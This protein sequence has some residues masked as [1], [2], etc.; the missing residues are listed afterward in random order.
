MLLACA[1]R[2]APR[3]ASTSV[4][5]A[6]STAMKYGRTCG[7][8][9]SYR[10]SSRSLSASPAACM[11]GSLQ[12]NSGQVRF[13]QQY[14][15]S[16]PHASLQYIG[17]TQQAQSPQHA[18]RVQA[19]RHACTQLHPTVWGSHSVQHSPLLAC[20]VASRLRLCTSRRSSF[21]RTC[22]P[23]AV[24]TSKPQLRPN[25][26][27]RQPMLRAGRQGGSERGSLR[28][29]QTL[30]RVH[31]SNELVLRYQVWH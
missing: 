11:P 28:G 30:V 18:A 29:S 4:R 23:L 17:W 2:T 16:V 21:F 1:S 15:P 8:S 31:V 10:T 6:S 26:S 20:C 27:C 5:V 13:E 12:Y 9:P 7:T 22:R 19:E 24:P 3:M 14:V 25:R